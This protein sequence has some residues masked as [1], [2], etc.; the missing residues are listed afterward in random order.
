VRR[1]VV[2]ISLLILFGLLSWYLFVRSFEF[3]VKFK[4][5]TL[6]GDVVQTIRI[7][8]KRSPLL[9]VIKVDSTS[10]LYQNVKVGDRDYFYIWNFDMQND[11]LTYVNIKI[12]EP[13]HA[14]NNKL[15][16]PFVE[17][18]IEQDAKEVIYDFID[19]INEHLKITKV[20]IEG[21]DYTREVPCICSQLIT[22]Q[23]SKAQ[24]MMRDYSEL[25]FYVADNNFENNGPPLVEITRWNH[26][27]GELEYNF[28]M[29][30]KPIN[31][32]PEHD[33]F[34]YK[35]QKKHKSLKAIYNGNYI[36]SDRAWYSL[37]KYAKEHN[38]EITN[39]PIEYFYNNPNL[40]I[41]EEGWKAEIY[42]P[43]KEKE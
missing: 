12:S 37:V 29:P 9:S 13:D 8:S 10:S 38:F 35:R 32:I 21:I 31:T 42:L 5:K 41:N 3:E 34:F 6:P 4:T 7:W 26:S 40:G 36:T 22:N 39:Y 11:T 19:I 28:C 14:L 27:L 23:H 43:V 1:L 15:L 17:Q 18:P 20:K 24:G 30:I 25:A 2:G 16:I 33:K